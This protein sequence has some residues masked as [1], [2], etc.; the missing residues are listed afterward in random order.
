MPRSD[1]SKADNAAMRHA[2]T[3]LAISG[4]RA[5]FSLIYGLY[6]E[7][8]VRLAFRLC[9][10][11]AAA[12][13]ITQNA[14]IIM[15]RKIGR[16]RRPEAFPAWGYRIIR[17]RAQDY[18]RRQKRRPHIVPLNDEITGRQ[19]GDIDRDLT[20]RQSLDVLPPQDRQLLILFYIDGFT[21]AEIS[22]ATGLPLGTVK[23]RLYK[24]RQ[25]LKATFNLEGEYNE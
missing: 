11:H 19:V 6:H 10:D 8:F 5:A 1:H 25:Q 4:D 21:G 3:S 12:Q 15:A 13:D 22:A 17:F 16:L 24:I 18:F 7:R 14:A 20:L 23:S 9:G 2:V